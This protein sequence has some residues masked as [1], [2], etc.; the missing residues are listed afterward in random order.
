VR[1]TMG[2]QQLSNVTDMQLDA[3]LQTL[4]VH[5]HTSAIIPILCVLSS[6]AHAHK[7]DQTSTSVVVQRKH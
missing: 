2:T 6:G 7:H 4:N 3:A 5:I 1:E